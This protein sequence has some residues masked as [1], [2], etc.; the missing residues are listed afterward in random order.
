VQESVKVTVIVELKLLFVSAFGNEDGT[1]VPG[2]DSPTTA[3]DRRL[4]TAALS[5]SH[6]QAT[7][8]AGGL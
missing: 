2:S 6:I 7:G 4:P 3:A 1:M 8:F 5:G